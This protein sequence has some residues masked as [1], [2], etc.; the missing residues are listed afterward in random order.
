[1]IR[2]YGISKNPGTDEFVMVM[3]YAFHGNLRQY[4]N[5]SFSSLRWDEKSK[6]LFF[7]SSGLYEIHE[8]GLIHCDFHSG[9][10]LMDLNNGAY[11]S[12]LGLCRPMNVTNKKIY[13]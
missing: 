8:S 5:K 11:V 10:I 3:D 6:I 2:C 13:G 1:M 4:L 7:M 9:N 12:D